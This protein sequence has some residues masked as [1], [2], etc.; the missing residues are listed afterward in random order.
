MPRL[1]FFQEKEHLYYIA[2]P[3]DDFPFNV[4]LAGISETNPD[5]KASILPNVSSFY[6]HQFEYVVSGQGSIEINDRTIN[7]SAGDFFFI[8]K[9]KNRIIRSD[10]N[11]PLVKLY[12]SAKG[13]P[14]EAIL[15][16]YNFKDDAIALKIDL[17]NQF[18]E[19]LEIVKTSTGTS[20]DICDKLGMII[21]EIIQKVYSQREKS[22]PKYSEDIALQIQ[23]YIE[24]NINRN[25]TLDDLYRQ[26]FLGKTQLIK[27]FKKRHKCTPLYYHQK[28][29][30]DIAKD[31]LR[32]PGTKTDEL[33]EFL[34]FSD[35]V[36]FTRVFKKHT[37][38]TLTEYK[39]KIKGM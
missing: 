21:L 23:D 18:D 27:V 38:M 8:R 13:A 1:D 2:A 37:G 17:K 3:F 14:L 28:R 7:I 33:A 26:F 31:Y 15:S 11:N 25:L 9:G 32:L 5:Y 6:Y 19:I 4:R 12:L 36:Y 34:G 20:R 30:I 10:R 39:K 35:T 22:S 24:L 29:K 16:A